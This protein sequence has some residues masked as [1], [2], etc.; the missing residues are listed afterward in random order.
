MKF[1]NITIP[2]EGRNKYGNYVSS[3][4]LQKSVVRVTYN[5]NNTTGGNQPNKPVVEPEDVYT[6]FL[7]RSTIKFDSKKL[8][9]GNITESI[10]VFTSSADRLGAFGSYGSSAP[11]YIFPQKQIR[12][13]S[14]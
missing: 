11:F 8:L 1:R 10:D 5:G 2:A 13:T 9:D 14:A 3:T 6:L 7:S 4:E 12:R